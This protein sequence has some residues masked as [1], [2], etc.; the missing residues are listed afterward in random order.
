MDASELEELGVYDPSAPDAADR[1]SLLRYL[2]GLGATREQML[3]AAEQDTMWSLAADLLLSQGTLTLAEVIYRVGAPEVI[4]RELIRSLGLPEPAPDE[5]VFSERDVEMMSFLLAG[6]GAQ[7]FGREDARQ[8]VRV[9]GSALA[10]IADAGIAMYLR[11][12]EATLVREGATELD[13]AQ[14]NV[15]GLVL[16]DQFA[17]QMPAMLAH[18]VRLAMERSRQSRVEVG[19]FESARVAV[20]FVDLVGFTPLSQQME[21]GE[22]AD[23]IGRFEAVAMD[24][25]TSHGGRVVKLIGDEVMFVAVEVTQACEIATTLLGAF[26]GV[27]VTP[28]GGMAYGEV[29]SRDGDYYGPL[30]NLASRIA[31]LAVPNEILVTAELRD[32]VGGDRFSAAGRRM[33][34][35]FDEPVELYAL[36]AV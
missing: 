15:E 19:D 16:F 8:F 33:L 36:S 5:R 22:L 9:T 32:A 28:R 17:A 14:A 2:S 3:A 6:G 25:A 35:G 20:G 26:P 24:T 27:G 31:D 30:V 29:L 12:V 7:M 1:L 23:L 4:V 10:R 21:P 11:G 34:K 18:H 13:H